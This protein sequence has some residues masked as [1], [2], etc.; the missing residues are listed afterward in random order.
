M[1]HRI[2]PTAIVDPTAEIGA[3]VEIGAYA[4][5]GPQVKLGDR[6]RVEHHASITGPTR[7]GS[8]NHFFPFAS[9]GQKTQDLKYKGEPTYLEIGNDNVF[10]EFVTANRGTAP[11]AVTRIGS[12]NLFLTYSH[13]AHD[14]TVGSHTIFSNNATLAGHVEVGDYAIISGLSAVHQFCR[15]GAHSMIGGC[16]KIVQDAP[17]FFIADGNPAEVRGVNAVGLQRRGFTDDDIKSLRLAYRI[18]YDKTLNTTQAVEKIE[19]DFAS[20]PRV[21]ELIA[22]V[23][24]SQRGIIR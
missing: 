24:S 2:H 10:R 19:K 9:I 11:E 8:G 5:V 1:S 13:V 21:A 7:I 17:P 12:N 14:C 15:I 18:L 23:R 3:D 20:Q 6:C 4:W 16:T 22:F